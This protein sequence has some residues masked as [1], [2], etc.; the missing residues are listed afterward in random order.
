MGAK[1]TSA[2]VKTAARSSRNGNRT[3]MKVARLH[4]LLAC[5]ALC[6]HVMA[7][8]PSIPQPLPNL[9][10]ASQWTADRVP[11]SFNYGG[12][13][14]ARLLSGWR[15]TRE[16]AAATA[17]QTRYSYTDPS[18]HLKVTAEVRTYA[19]FPGV[20]DWVVSF[21]N[22]GTTDTPILDNILPLDWGFAATGRININHG[23]GSTVSPDDFRPTQEHFWPQGHV[24]LEAT[25]GRS[26]S[27][28]S[29]PYFNMQSG[30]QGYIVAIGWSGGWKADFD[31]N[32]AENVA[33]M[34]VGMR[35]THLL[36][37]PGEEIRTPRMVVMPWA[38]PDWQESQN[39]WRQMLFAH[40]TPQDHGQPM[41]GPVLFGE[42]GSE[43]IHDKLAYIDWIHQNHIPV[44][45]YAT[46]AGWY[47]ASTGVE[48]DETS[49]WW[50]YRGDWYPSKLYYPHGIRPL[51]EELKTDKIGFSL[52]IEPEVAVIG[53]K[54]YREHPDWFLTAKAPLFGDHPHPEMAMVNLGN[55]AALAGITHLV[56]GL[57][58]DFEI[59]WYRQDFNV[60]PD[61]YWDAADTPDRIGMTEIGHIEGL[62]KFWDALLAE[63]PGLR[64]DNCAS[65]GRRLDIEMTSRSFSIWRT[66]YGFADRV[67]EQAQ[68]Q[69]LAYWVPQNEGFGTSPTATPWT[70]PGPYD[71]AQARYLMRV[72]YSMGF[73]LTPGATGVQNG[74][75][76]DW[77]KQ[78]LAEY[79]EVQPYFHGDFYPL[80]HSSLDPDAWTAWQWDRPQNKDGL[81]M[82]MRRAESP[83]PTA[84]LTLKHL[85]PD[86]IYDVEIRRDIAHSSS[87]KMKGSDLA[88]LTLTFETGPDS[89][90]IF[91]RR[92]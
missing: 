49:P 52:W 87:T 34:H 57:I 44:T 25:T 74:P 47:G 4:A 17:G 20:T 41:L 59:T 92:H 69:A 36:L 78:V 61:A 33:Q 55:P 19:D 77:V 21:K 84:Q 58:S 71:T 37:H 89:A 86:A 11:F 54:L 30:G 76:V 29:L 79:R 23:R 66:D 10:L 15:F 3:A 48:G 85:D 9:G 8:A 75:W 65:G 90:L 6:A 39:R 63:F 32:K 60:E 56:S 13:P 64:I 68:T 73:G 82:A 24:H 42:W 88:R 53:T 22:E 50:K 81:V 45:V 83:F 91:Y 14:S 7:Q 51:G 1:I 12:T 26:S 31:Y 46:D 28:E 35:R 80:M 62:Y 70:Q 16:T 5:I 72:G 27:G 43:S 67:A 40:Y 2:P 38:G 18:T